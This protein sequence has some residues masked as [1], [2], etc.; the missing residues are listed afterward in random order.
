MYR[1]PLKDVDMLQKWESAVMKL[2]NNQVWKA[3]RFSFICSNHFENQDYIIPP[4][5]DRP[6]RLKKYAVPSVFSMPDQSNAMGLSNAERNRLGIPRKRN[7]PRES[8]GMSPA[9]K[10]FLDHNYA[11]QMTENL[12]EGQDLNDN[13][14]EEAE[15]KP[16]LSQKLR[17]KIK[18]LQQKLRRSKNKLDNMG[19]LIS[20][21]QEKLVISS[22]QAGILHASFDNLQLS[23]FKNTKKNAKR[24]PSGR[25]YDDQVKEFALTLYFYSPKAYKYV[26][27]IIPLPDPSSLRGW[28]S[29]VNCEPG[30]S[31]EAF[32]AL[33]SEV[34][35]DAIKKDC[36][37]II[38]AMAIRKQTVYEPKNDRYVGFVN[39]GEGVPIPDDPDTM[40]TEAHVFLLVGSRSHWKCPVGYFLTDKIASLTQTQLIK[41]A[42]IKAAEAGLKVWSITA[43]GT[44]VNL[45]TF[46]QLGCQFGSTYNTFKTKFPHP[47][48]G[49]DV[50]VI[51]DPCHMLKLARNAL[52][53]LGTI[54]DDKGQTIQW[55]YFRELNK[56]Q[57]QEGLKMGNKLSLNHIKFE[58][59]KMNVRLAA[60][61]LSSSVADA[62]EFL[63]VVMKNTKF[64]DSNG[65]V[66]FIRMID[67]LF[68]MLNSRNPVGKGFK[69]PLRFANK[70]SY[71][72]V[73]KS[74]ATYLLSLKV[75]SQSKL[76]ATHRRKTFIIGF[77]TDIVSTIDMANQMFTMPNNPFKYILTYKYSQD[78]LELLFSC[79]RSRGGWNNNPNCLQLKYALRQMMMK[80][81]ITASKNA[82]CMD[83]ETNTI[84]PIF[85]R[86]KH[87]AP[88][89]EGMDENVNTQGQDEED[90]EENLMF[91][92]L[93]QNMHSDFISN[94]LFYIGGYIVKKLIKKLTCEECKKCLV[95]NI[96]QSDHDYCGAST[97]DEVS[98]ASAFTLFVNNGGLKI[99]SKSVFRTIEQCEH[100][101]KV[102]V[103]Q[104]GISTVKNLKNK[105][106]L[107][108][109]HHLFLEASNSVFADHETGNDHQMR[110][111]KWTADEYFTLR[112]FT[113]GKH[114]S[115]TV[116]Q[117]EM[118]SSRH[119]LNKMILFNN[120]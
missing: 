11:R 14:Q 18:N 52:A 102:S 32:N 108:V 15:E 64:Q 20:H 79:V 28:S 62:I 71:E 75:G 8:S 115:K 19:N 82:N 16:D 37:M 98:S 67:R 3:T 55:D 94:I 54:T 7:L 65:T 27:S 50:F 99:P 76:L 63:D 105:M 5:S 83:F 87:K 113:Y 21:L 92:R 25:R 120:Q 103:I 60:Q 36:C 4:S 90:V 48:T 84:I 57:Q 58:K 38:D 39:Y 86:K 77:V 114:F 45:S 35:R 116:G 97:Y 104:N 22:E 51:A 100:I 26:R 81:A 53:F 10:V 2:N 95:G 34:S 93:D 117:N 49:E 33:A 30:F 96:F 47:T 6:C 74:T 119:H 46:E 69:Q 89:S 59:H 68:D 24:K 88:L 44:S 43:D 107:K 40:A 1:F 66:R 118:P 101:F 41:M 112:L 61:T 78:H 73:L 80:N 31:E 85:H 110:L 111:I 29:S 56:L 91:E 106:I 42:L 109:C 9:A 17:Q 72:E 23:L 12:A 13:E 70:A